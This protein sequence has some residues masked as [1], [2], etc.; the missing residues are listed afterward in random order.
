[1]FLMFLMFNLFLPIL[2]N[3]L[4][5]QWTPTIQTLGKLDRRLLLPNSKGYY[6]G[7]LS[8]KSKKEKVGEKTVSSLANSMFI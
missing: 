1:M 8:Q 5:G 7:I 4:T 3:T 6:N 2:K